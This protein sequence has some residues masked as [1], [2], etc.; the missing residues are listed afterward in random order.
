MSISH[1]HHLSRFKPHHPCGF[2][3]ALHCLAHRSELQPE[4]DDRSILRGTV[5]VD[6]TSVWCL[7]ISFAF[8]RLL[9]P[10]LLQRRPTHAALTELDRYA[11]WRLGRSATSKSVSNSAGISFS[12]SLT[13]RGIDGFRAP[14]G[15]CQK[16]LTETRNDLRRRRS[17]KRG[18]GPA[19]PEP[20]TS[21]LAKNA[22]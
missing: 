7:V 4:I 8:V 18:S 10:R 6:L 12:K 16:Q 15:P 9:R 20:G 22:R 11:A 17:C 21:N 1:G 5:P 13:D 19:S 14:A 2:P 3:G